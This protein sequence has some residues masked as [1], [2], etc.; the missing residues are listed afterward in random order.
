MAKI[1]RESFDVAVHR[2]FAEQEV[3]TI[4]EPVKGHKQRYR[5]E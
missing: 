1:W 5:T 4:A 3:R 2:G